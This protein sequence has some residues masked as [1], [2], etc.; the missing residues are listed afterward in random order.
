MGAQLLGRQPSLYGE[1]IHGDGRGRTLGFPTANLNLYH[2]A[3]PPH[4]VYIAEVIRFEDTPAFPRQ[5]EANP[6]GALI[7]I[8]RR[9]TFL[10]P[11]DPLDYSRYFN[12]QLDKVEIYIHDFEGDL[13]GGRLEAV[14]HKKIRDERRFANV[15]E[16]VAQLEVDR[17]G[18]VRWMES[19]G[20][21]WTTP[22]DSATARSVSSSMFLGWSASAARSNGKR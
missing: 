12:E 21:M 7:N 13:Y 11:D 19:T 3:A 4:G 15:D 10:N 9:P 8:G 18:L 2:S 5:E 1:V 20:T 14:I 16:L 17:D 22:P 6:H